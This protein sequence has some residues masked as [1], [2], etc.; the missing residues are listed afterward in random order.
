MRVIAR[1]SVTVV[2]LMTLTFTSNVMAQQIQ[3]TPTDTQRAYNDRGVQHMFDGDFEQA[4]AS[5]KSSL[6]LG[7]SN[8]AW[9]N[10]G[11]A[12]FKMKRCHEA[13][14]AYDAVPAAPTVASP[15]AA[16]I[17]TVLDTFSQ[18]WAELCTARLTLECP[19][20]GAQVRIDDSS[21]FACHTDPIPVVPGTHQ[22]WVAGF[23]EPFAV[24]V[25]DEPMLLSLKRSLTPPIVDE[26]DE[27]KPAPEPTGVEEELRYADAGLGTRRT[28]GL[29]VAG[30]G[31]AA[32][33]TSLVLELA[34]VS[35]AFDDLEAAPTP[36]EWEVA[37]D[38]A[39]G[40]QRANRILFFTGLGA[41]AIG[42]TLFMIPT[43]RGAVTLRTAGTGI[44]AEVTW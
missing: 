2:L 18:E 6:A 13:L 38:R 24:T 3:V 21:P 5:F 7:E 30:T 28:V 33:A 35:P 44:S 1:I 36:A 31:I 27:T 34:V 8:I 22:V 32:L 43:Q 42:A 29:A 14:D 25:R 26:A 16:E 41:T 10:Y 12:L 39:R 17:A 11:R 4:A 40:A 23:D 15:S 9:L 19:D 37:R 20:E